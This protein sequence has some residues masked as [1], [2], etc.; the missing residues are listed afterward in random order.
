MLNQ[1]NVYANNFDLAMLVVWS[2]IGLHNRQ[3][4]FMAAL[5]LSYLYIQSVTSTNFCGFLIAS[6][7]FFSIA[8]INIRIPS[9]FRQA[10]IFFGAVYFLGAADQAIYYHTEVDMFFDRIQPYLITAI[11]AYLL[12]YLISGGGREGAKHNGLHIASFCRRIFRLS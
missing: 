2:I 6:A 4:F 8:I 11:N 12:A 10:F 1:L 7:M 9:E 5:L 3:S